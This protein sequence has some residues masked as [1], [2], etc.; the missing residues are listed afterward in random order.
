VAAAL[1]TVELFDGQLPSSGLELRL[2]PGVGDHASQAILCF[3]F[4]R[5]TVLLDATTARVAGRVLGREDGRRWQLRLDLHRLAGTDGPDARFNEAILDLGAEVCVPSN[6]DCPA[7]PLRPVC[8]SADE[9]HQLRLAP[10]GLVSD[11]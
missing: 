2:I 9:S 8:A 3:G 7:C 5:S 11:R 6:P 4:G 10:G 1:A